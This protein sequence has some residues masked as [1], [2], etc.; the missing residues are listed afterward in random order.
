VS[1]KPV[2]RRSIEFGR[3]SQ[4]EWLIPVEFE[5]YRIITLA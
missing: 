2:V 1:N 3:H 5:R 4:L